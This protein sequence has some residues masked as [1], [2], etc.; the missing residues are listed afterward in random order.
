MSLLL[1]RR[2]ILT[3]VGIAAG[4]TVA[5]VVGFLAYESMTGR[6]QVTPS[7]PVTAKDCS[8][9]PCANVR[10]YTLWVSHPTVDGNLVRMQVRFK[11]SSG[12]THASPE[13]LQLIDSAQHS[14]GLI[15]DAAE[16]SS[17]AR[18]EFNNGASFGPID[19]CFR[20]TTATSPFTLRWSPD[21]GFL[22]CQQDITIALT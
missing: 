8:P 5:A 6:V 2:R 18:H 16:C 12:S 10:G 3:Y 22:C 11:N 9:A 15:T 14:S 21:F 1:A 7:A 17:W 20:V 13:D 19:V 4:L